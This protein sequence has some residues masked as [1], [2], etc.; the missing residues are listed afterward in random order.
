MNIIAT[1]KSILSKQPQ[2]VEKPIADYKQELLFRQGKEQFE[3][4]LQRGLRV[5]V[6]LL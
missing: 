6:A 1:I 4:L 3:K 2:T 5:P